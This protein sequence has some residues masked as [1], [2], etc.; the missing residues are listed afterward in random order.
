MRSPLHLGVIAIEK[1]A[2]RCRG[3]IELNCELMLNWIVLNRTVYVYMN[4][5]VIKYL[6]WLICH[7]TKPD[8][9]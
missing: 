1:G 6:Q 3:Q 5:F 9:T 4:K 2:F 7:K 8:K